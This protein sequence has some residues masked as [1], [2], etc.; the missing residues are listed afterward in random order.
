[1]AMPMESENQSIETQPDSFQPQSKKVLIVLNP[2]AGLTDAENARGI[3]SRFCSEHNW[4]LTLHET[5]KR[6]DVSQVVRDALKNGVD[7]VIA[8]GGDGTVSEVV[9]GMLNSNIPMGILPAGTGNALARDV[10]IPID[11]NSA[12]AL[13]DGENEIRAIDVMEV[14]ACKYYALNVSVGV[15]SMTM[16]STRRK[17]KRRFGML[18]YLYR[19][20]GAIQA[21]DLYR[22]EVSVDG[23]PVRFMASELMIANSKLL[24]FQPQMEGIQV[25]PSDGRLDLFIIRA[26]SIRSYLS[27]LVRSFI[28]GSLYGDPKLHYL[29]ASE[30]IR[31]TTKTPLPV[32]ADGE[33]IGNTPVDVRLIPG[34]LR[35][36]VPVGKGK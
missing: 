13:L 19:S 30:A 36:I 11:I 32:Q 33:V 15:S 16:R 5:Q 25:D 2:V 28:P 21:A 12:L 6:E 23:I 20:I 22:F 8:A 17:E 35:L 24:G 31:I 9:S 34:A 14:N 4:D 27:L 7:M 18:A 26:K 3:I 29:K 1:M 10:G